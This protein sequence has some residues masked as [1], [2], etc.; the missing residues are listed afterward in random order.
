M[1]RPVARSRICSCPIRRR[2]RAGSRR[3]CCRWRRSKPT[4]SR[5][6]DSK[7]ICGEALLIDRFR[8][9][10]IAA[11]FLKRVRLEGSGDRARWTLLVDE[12]TVFDLP[13]EQLRQ[14]E[15]EFTP[16]T[17]R[18]LRVTWDDTRSGRVA[19]SCG[20]LRARC[21]GCL[22]SAAADGG[23]RLRATAERAGPQPLPCPPAGWASADRRPRARRWRRSPAAARHRL[24]SALVG[25]RGRAGAAR[26]VHTSPRRP[27][28]TDRSVAA[29][30]DP[31]SDRSAARSRRGRWRQPAAGAA[32]A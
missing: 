20:R 13:A 29:R 7:S 4:R 2:R 30:A 8:V 23:R 17:Y 22:N 14:T 9:D 1:T 32:K 15:L 25:R 24:R 11:P 5:R 6:A 3:R 16:G 28:H 26:R 12:G 27:E 10:G 19:D 21:H 18:Y 31:S